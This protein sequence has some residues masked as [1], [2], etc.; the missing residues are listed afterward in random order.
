MRIVRFFYERLPRWGVV[1]NNLIAVLKDHP[2]GKIE[3]TGEKAVFSKVVL[4]APACPSKIILVGLNYRDH[5]RE[6]GMAV[7]KDPVIFLKPPSSLI[8]HQKNIVYPRNVKRLDYEAELALVIKK[9]GRFIKEKNASEHILGYSCLNDVTA[10]DV[11]KKDGQWTRAKSFDTFCP[12]GPWLETEL[13]TDDLAIASYLNGKLMQSSTTANVIFSVPFLLSYISRIMTLLPGDI[14]S[15]GTPP[16]VGKMK[17]RD[18]IEV[19][20][21]GIGKLK[22]QVR[23]SGV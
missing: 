1:E 14:I 19:E 23:M 13:E 18:I 5:A 21:E 9:E 11:Q 20:I 12:F 8:A 10:R 15:T 4:C 16:G 2:F 3:F 17:N 22:N 7:P 6:L